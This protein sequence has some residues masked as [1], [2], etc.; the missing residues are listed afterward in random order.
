MYLCISETITLKTQA[1]RR[2]SLKK[3]YSLSFLA[4]LFVALG[5]YF[6]SSLVGYKVVALILMLAVSVIAMFFDILPVLLSAVL[7]ALVWNFFF[8]PPKFTFSIHSAE[9]ALMFSMYFVIAS[10]NAVLT[11]KI[12]QIEKEASRKEEK[13]N[14][15]MLYNT[16]L[17]SLSHELKTPISTIIG[18]SDNLQTMSDKLSEFDKFELVSEISK[19]S[20]QLNRQVGN[21]LN[22]SRLESGVIKPKNDWFD[23]G[24]LVYDVL[25]Q[26]K[27]NIGETPVHVAIKEN[28]PLFRLDYGLL[29]QVLHNLVH[30]A[31]TYLPKYSVVTIRAFCKE[32]KMVLVVE[33]TGNGFPEA[34][35]AHVFDK[36]YRLKNTAPGGTGLGLSIVKGFVDAMK[37]SIKL[38]NMPE[39]GAVFTV[40][41]PSELSYVTSQLRT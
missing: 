37:G 36:F 30:N 31:L 41:I 25:N 16:V 18:A 26:L 2:L 6:I 3:Q 29:S 15:L 28:T 27:D 11:Y 1:F 24:E 9:D 22:M 12:R 14:T 20:L 17:N 40:E 13:E 19:A 35:I 34:E 38:A 7:S 33:D 8:I 10:V 39:G 32:D 23:V 21:L 4:I 5:C